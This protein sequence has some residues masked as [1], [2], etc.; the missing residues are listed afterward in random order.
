MTDQVRVYGSVKISANLG[1]AWV[2][3]EFGHERWSDDDMKSIIAKKREIFALN[4]KVVDQE[5]DKL[6]E[7]IN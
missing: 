3:V 7:K 5:M 1:D 6:A 2:T 4:H